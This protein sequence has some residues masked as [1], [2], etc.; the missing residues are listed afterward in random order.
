[1]AKSPYNNIDSS[2]YSGTMDDERDDAMAG[3]EEEEVL[4]EAEDVVDEEESSEEIT[5][6]AN[7]AEYIEDKVLSKL[8]NE[9]DSD[10]EDDDMSR[11]E[12]KDQMKRVWFC[13]DLSTKSVQ[14]RLTVPQV[15][16]ILF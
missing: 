13:L 8:I 11:E 3:Q 4:Q 9:L 14:N 5:F 15:S 6:D 2:V 7:L 10:I 16:H 12:W 1:M